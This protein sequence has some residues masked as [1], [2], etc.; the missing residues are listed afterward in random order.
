MRLDGIARR[1]YPRRRH[2][3]CGRSPHLTEGE[4]LDEAAQCL[5][6]LSGRNRRRA[7]VDL[8]GDTER[9]FRRLV[10]SA[11]AFKRLSAEDIEAVS[12]LGRMARQGRRLCVAEARRHFHGEA[13]G[14]LQQCRRTCRCI[15]ADA[16]PAGGLSD[17]F[18]LAQCA[19]SS[20]CARAAREVDTVAR[21]RRHLVTPQGRNC[22]TGRHTGL[23][24]SPPLRLC[25][26]AGR[27]ARLACSLRGRIEAL[28]RRPRRHCRLQRAEYLEALYG[29]W[30]AGLRRGAGQCQAASDRTRL[31]TGSFRRAYLFRLIRSCTRDRGTCPRLP[32][33]GHRV[34]L[35]LLQPPA[36]GRCDG[37]RAARE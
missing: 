28:N 23:S 13:R 19:V 17:P 12:C 22:R 11:R 16:L 1:L 37:C 3:G 18:R 30:H 10:G 9:N 7:Y 34:R 5:R 15:N 2:R 35:E 29:I 36:C 8:H 32:S 21:S 33:S 20:Q 27:V 4:L 26:L 6:L 25:E 31:Y 24:A 14:L